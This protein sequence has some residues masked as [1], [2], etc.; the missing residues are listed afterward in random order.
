MSTATD[1]LPLVDTAAPVDEAEVAE[2]IRR[3]RG[4]GKAVYP[5]GG[6]TGL[7]Y[8]ARPEMPGVG[9]S[10]R[11]LDRII[12]H[13]P[14]D[15]TVTAQAGLTAARLSERLADE[16][17]RLPVDVPH[18]E[19]ATL[20]GLLSADP[21]GPRRFSCGTVRDYVLG[22]RAV[23]GRGVAFS[24]G[25][26]VLKNAAGYDLCRM[27]V[28]SLGT[29]AVITQVTLK[30]CPVPQTSAML[31]CEVPDFD[32][33]ERLLEGLMQTQTRPA[34]V[35]LLAG[36]SH[37]GNP[38][39]GPMLESSE[40]QLL[41]GFEGTQ[42]E[43]DW[44]L[45]GLAQEWQ[46][47]AGIDSPVTIPAVEVSPVWGWLTGLPADVQINAPPSA[48]VALIEKLRGID[49]NGSIQ[50]HAGDGVIRVYL[51]PRV[52][53]EFTALVDEKLRPA[54][55]AAGGNLAVLT[56]PDGAEMTRDQIWGPPGE[57][58][59]LVRAIKDRFDPHGLLNPGRFRC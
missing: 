57:G 56:L 11:R 10:L 43:V 31:V 16:G 45:G 26:R 47:L 15:M 3:A 34:A 58:M 4:E 32:S 8:G 29:L 14:A 44:M 21:S 39:I 40:A 33:A 23:D 2:I 12:E 48:T 9:L 41:V 6:G 25:G 36:A 37:Q 20:G 55:A 22:L 52:P 1:L 51:S 13:T 59:A 18:P 38:A 19:R 53:A 17:Q 7:D 30:V 54:A 27:M 50:A 49:P 28:G 5:I 46:Q 35:E 24:A 42:P